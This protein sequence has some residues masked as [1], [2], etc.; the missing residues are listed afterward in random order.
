MIDG[1]LDVHDGEALIVEQQPGF[2]T[3]VIGVSSRERVCPAS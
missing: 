2:Q 3:S 1:G